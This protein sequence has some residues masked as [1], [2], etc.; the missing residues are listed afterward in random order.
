MEEDIRAI[1]KNNTW[2]LVSL[3][4]DKKAISVKWCTK[5]KEVHMVRSIARKLI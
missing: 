1:K 3:S 2:N 5:S 4:K